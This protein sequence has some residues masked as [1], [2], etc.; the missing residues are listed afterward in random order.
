LQAKIHAQ[1]SEVTSTDSHMNIVDRAF[2]MARVVENFVQKARHFFYCVMLVGHRCPKCDGSLQIVAEGRCKCN[3]CG[4]EFDPTVAFQSCSSCGGTPV[5]R[6]RKYQC[7]DCGSD[8][9]SKF[10]FDGLVFDAEYFRQRV[11][12]SRQRKP[13]GNG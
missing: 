10:L 11:A 1:I 4:S 12:Q 8:I 13:I 9:R 3:S 6:V 5:L 2:E 7:K